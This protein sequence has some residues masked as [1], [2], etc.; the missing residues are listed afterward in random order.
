VE[1]DNELSSVE[2]LKEDLLEKDWQRLQDLPPSRQQLIDLGSGT[3]ALRSWVTIARFKSS[4]TAG[5]T[6]SHSMFQTL[7]CY[8]MLVLRLRKHEA[9]I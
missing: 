6:G 7:P 5:D 8:H 1:G 9:K 2:M 3:I 4:D